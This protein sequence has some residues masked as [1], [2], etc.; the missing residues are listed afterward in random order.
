VSGQPSESSL[1]AGRRSLSRAMRTRRLAAPP[2]AIWGVIED[3][4]T[5]PRW[6]PGV[7][8]IEG[9][10]EDRFTQVLRTK[11]QRAVRMDF[12]VLVSAPPGT[13][14]SPAGHRT[15][16]QEVQGTPFERVLHQAVTEVLL[17]PADG[18][19]TQ[20]TIAQLQ[21]LRGYSRTGTLLLRRATD[22]RLA[23]ALDGLERI[24]G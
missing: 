18:G 19:G 8:R 6:W 13:G 4:F 5:M 2:E 10:A 20:V 3:P 22:K 12:R 15:W 16:E 9:V 7:E 11:R 14:G 17:E 23:E 21:K 1:V 24:C